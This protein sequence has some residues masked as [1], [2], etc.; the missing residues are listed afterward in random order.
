M[1]NCQVFKAAEIL[2]KK[3]TI[4][5]LQEIHSNSGQGFSELSRNMKKIS[6]KVLTQRL[7]ELENNNL[8]IKSKVKSNNLI[9]TAYS[10]TPEGRDMQRIIYLL[11][12]LNNRNTEIPC[13]KKRCVECGDY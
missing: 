8:V 7:R 2:G 13:N 3:W 9:K 10:I 11:K 5:I 12:E 4:P 6:P 1:N